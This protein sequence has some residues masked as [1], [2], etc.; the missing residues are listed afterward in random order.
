MPS[1]EAESDAVLFVVWLLSI[2]L[3]QVD[4]PEPEVGLLAH[5]HPHCQRVPAWLGDDVIEYDL[6][7]VVSFRPPQHPSL[8]LET[9]KRRNLFPKYYWNC[10][11]FATPLLLTLHEYLSWTNA[12][13]LVQPYE[14]LVLWLPIVFGIEFINLSHHRLRLGNG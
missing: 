2:L 5:H 8:H 3:P 10:L 6:L 11:A 1:F 14:R 4:H 13:E 7:V 12:I 9:L